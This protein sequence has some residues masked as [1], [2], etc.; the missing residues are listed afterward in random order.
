MSKKNRP[1]DSGGNW[2]DTYG[3][4]VTLLLTFFIMLYS[5]SN[6]DAQKWTVFVKSIQ[7]MQESEDSDNITINNPISDTPD[8]DSAAQTLGEESSEEPQEVDMNKLYLT[9]A[10]SLN[11][12]D[13][14]NATVIRGDD[15][16]YVSF[17]DNMFFAPDSSVLTREGQNVLRVFS[18]A[19]APAAD[20]IDEI[21]IMAHTAKATNHAQDDPRITRKDRMLSA[22]R[23]AEVCIYLQLQNVIQPEKLVDM[24]YGEYRPIEDNSTE[25]GRKKNRRVELLILDRDARSRKLDEYYEEFKSGE[26]NATTV[27]TLGSTQNDA[28]ATE[29]APAE[30]GA[31]PAETGSAPAE[32]GAVPPEAGSVPPE[33]AGAAPA[34]AGTVPAE[35]GTVPAEAGPPPADVGAAP[36]EP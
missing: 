18:E 13:V 25:R 9:I 36:A 19:I 33:A 12:A 15:Y 17:A 10:A 8:E 14:K 16:T 23:S 27:L 24:S 11:Q 31:V 28:E 32:A 30:T 3:D 6:V 1:T 2:M 20:W 34:E 22:M 29:P 35:A 21:T 7:G 26:Y 4:M 5:M